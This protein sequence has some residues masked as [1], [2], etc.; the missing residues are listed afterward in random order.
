MWN[1]SFVPYKL[2]ERRVK[3]GPLSKGV[4][5]NNSFM[6]FYFPK[7]ENMAGGKVINS[8]YNLKKREGIVTFKGDR[9]PLSALRS[10]YGDATRSLWM[11][12]TAGDTWTGGD[13]YEIG[14]GQRVA[15]SLK[16]VK[17]ISENKW[18]ATFVPYNMEHQI[19]EAVP[20]TNT[21]RKRGMQIMKHFLPSKNGWFHHTYNESTGV[22]HVHIISPNDPTKSK[23]FAGINGKLRVVGGY[24]RENLYNGSYGLQLKIAR[25]QQK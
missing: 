22:G 18:K 16:D 2:K 11:G 15:P 13:L 9:S 14:N 17:R 24:N 19:V 21:E 7:G 25:K 1:V 23:R 12:D 6:S 20:L 5:L 8:E 10:N 4:K 3:H